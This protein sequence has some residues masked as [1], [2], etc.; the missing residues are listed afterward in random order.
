MRWSKWR[1][2]VGFNA[3]EG[4]VLHKVGYEDGGRVRPVL[5]RAS[6]AEMAVPYGQPDYPYI[7]KCAFDVGDYGG[8]CRVVGPVVLVGGRV[9]A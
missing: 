6:L 9:V 2:R 3:R 8:C 5:H 1:L 7:R 4:L